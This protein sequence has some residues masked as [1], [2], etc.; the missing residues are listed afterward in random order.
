M[1]KRDAQSFRQS[2][3]FLVEN[4]QQF[5]ARQFIQRVPW[6]GL[7][8]RFFISQLCRRLGPGFN[9]CVVSDFIK[10][11]AEGTLLDNGPSFAGQDQKRSLEC[12]L[13]ILLVAQH[14][15]ANTEDQRTM[16]PDQGLKG[17]VILS[18]YESLE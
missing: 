10:P 8:W 13:G 7:T 17:R 9:G 16:S 6:S 18:I 14:P 11:A 3:H 2:V 4:G 15:P 5:S 1:H 12:V